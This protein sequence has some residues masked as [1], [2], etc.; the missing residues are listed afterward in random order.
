[1]NDDLPHLGDASSVPVALGIASAAKHSPRSRH[2]SG[3]HTDVIEEDPM[4]IERP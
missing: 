4:L 2:V 1:M 3:D